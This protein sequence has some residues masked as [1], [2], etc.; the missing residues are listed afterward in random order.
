MRQF[1]VSDVGRHDLVRECDELVPQK[2]RELAIW[3]FSV[4]CCLENRLLAFDSKFLIQVA[5]NLFSGPV[6]VKSFQMF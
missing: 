2:V 3:R 1:D 5:D 6:V 4:S